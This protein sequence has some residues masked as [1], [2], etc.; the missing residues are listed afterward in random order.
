[1]DISNNNIFFQTFTIQHDEV[2]VDH[3]VKW[4]KLVDGPTFGAFAFF[5]GFCECYS[6]FAVLVSF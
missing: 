2:F 1:M 6:A 3:C 4:K 5:V